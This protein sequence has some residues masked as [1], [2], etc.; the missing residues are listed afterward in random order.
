MHAAGGTATREYRGGEIQLLDTGAVGFVTREASVRFV[1]FKC[2]QESS[3]DQ[4]SSSDEPY[5]VI[6]VD[7]GDGRPVT[8]KFGPFENVNTGT[9]ITDGSLI[10]DKIAPN[11]MAVKVSAYEND[12]GDPDETAK[13]L[14]EKLVELS[15]AAA[16][17]EGGSGA[18][19]ADGPGMGAAGAAG[20]AGGAIAGPLGALAAAGIVA[21]L[22]LGDDF[23]SQD[24]ALAFIDE[25]KTK[26]PHEHLTPD[27]EFN[28]KIT[29]DGQDEGIYEVFFD[30]QVVAVRDPIKI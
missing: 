9:V 21:V 5:F 15:K 19:A 8:R 18:D 6:T 30:I 1:G 17:A 7:T 26:E 28:T 29:L 20:A 22:G 24:A 11:P 14:Q 4:L 2:V 27:A 13:N 25:I 10:V 3:S 16:L 12:R 23:I